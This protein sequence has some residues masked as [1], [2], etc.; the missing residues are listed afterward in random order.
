MKRY[1]CIKSFYMEATGELAFKAGDTYPADNLIFKSRV[2]DRHAMSRK[3]V[4]L[5]FQELLDLNVDDERGSY[6]DHDSDDYALMIPRPKT[7]ATGC[8]IV[9]AALLTIIITLL[10]M[11]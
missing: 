1:Q 8:A 2:S 3:N 7:L 5:H 9:V 11:I 6:T 4:E 10:S